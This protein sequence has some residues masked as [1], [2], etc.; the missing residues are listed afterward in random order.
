MAKSP[1]KI[2]R[3]WVIERKPF[4]REIKNDEFYN[5]WPWRKKRKSFL[6]NNPICKHCE[7]MGIITQARVVD[8]IVSIKRGG[9]KLDDENLQSLCDSC[10]NRKSANE[11]RGMG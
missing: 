5:S 9:S 7:A 2:K 4:E 10:H 6:I 8:H 3:P 11:S 1:G